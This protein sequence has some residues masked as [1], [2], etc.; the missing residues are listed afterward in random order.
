M[1]AFCRSAP[2]FAALPCDSTAF[3]LFNTVALEQLLLAVS[4]SA[5]STHIC[6]LTHGVILLV[7]ESTSSL[8]EEAGRSVQLH[9]IKKTTETVTHNF[10][11]S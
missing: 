2:H 8:A 3:L 1:Q 11:K 6:I 10:V 4:C 9:R 7:I 5:F